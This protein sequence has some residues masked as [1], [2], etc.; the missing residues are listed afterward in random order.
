MRDCIVQCS[1]PDQK[2]APKDA[3]THALNEHIS[4]MD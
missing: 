3:K 1:L 2:G 4:K